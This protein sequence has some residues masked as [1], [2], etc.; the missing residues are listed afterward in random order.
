VLLLLLGAGARA[1]SPGSLNTSF[2]PGTGAN[3][4]VLGIVRQSD[5]KLVIGGQFTT[6]NGVARGRVARLNYDGSLDTSFD[7]GSGPDST[8]NAVAVGADG[9]VVAGGD[10]FGVNGVSR[11]RLAR[12]YVDGSLD[13]TFAPVVNG[14]IQA[15][16]VDPAGR[17]YL[18]GSFTLVN[19]VSRS[20]VARLNID[21]TLDLTF[22]PGTGP[23]SSV[24]GLELL[25][26]G[27]VLLAGYF[28]S[29]NGVTRHR[30]ARLNTDGTVDTTFVPG[31]LDNG[32]ANF[33]STGSDGK[34]LVGGGLYVGLNSRLLRLNPNGSVDTTFNVGNN[35]INSDVTT[36]VSHANGTVIIAGYFTAVNGVSRNSVARLL[37]NGTLDTAFNPGV[38]ANNRITEIVLEPDGSFVAGG[39]FT[40]YQGVSRNRITRIHSLF[41]NQAPV[42]TVTNSTILE[43][44]VLASVTVTGIAAGPV[45]DGLTVVPQAVTNLTATSSNPALVPDPLVTYTPGATTATLAFTP[46]ANATGTVTITVVAQ[47]NSG[48]A[49]LGNDRSTNT[50][51]L[52]VAP[53]NDAPSFTLATSALSSVGAVG[54][55]SV[56]AFAAN[57]LPGPANEA[58]QTVSFSVANNNNLLFSTQPAI[59]ANGTLTF[60]PAVM[61]NGVATVTVIAQ[62]NGGTANGGVDTSAAQTFTLTVV[63]GNVPPS[64]SYA[65]NNVVVLEDAAAQTVGAFA[66]FSAGPVNE[67]TQTVS[68]VSVTAANPALFSS[69]PALAANGTLTF[70]PAANANGATLVTVVVADDGGTAS[71]GAD[72]ATNTFTITVTPVNDAPGFALPAGPAVGGSGTLWS[73][74]YNEYG[75]IGNGTTANQLQP[76]AVLTTGVLADKTVTSVSVGNAHGLALCSDGTVAAWGR[77]LYGNLGTGNNN[78]SSVPVQVIQTGVLAGKTVTQVAAGSS[79]SLALC[80]DGT[81]VAWGQGNNGTLGNGGTAHVNQP[82]LV[83]QT[84]VLAGKTVTRIAGG[85]NQSFALCSDGTLVAWGYNNLGQLGTGSTSADVL[86]PALVDQSGVL[87]GKTVTK[88]AAG[89][90]HSLALCAD[91][92]LVAWGFNGSG[93]LGIGNLTS[94]ASPVLVDRSGVLAGKTVVEITVGQSHSAVLCA[95]GTIASWGRGYDSQLGNGTSTGDATLPVLVDRSGVLAGKTVTELQGGAVNTYALCSDGSVVVWGEGWFGGLGNGSTTPS[96]VPVLVSTSGLPA[97]QK[98]VKLFSGMSVGYTPMAMVGAGGGGGGGGAHTLTVAEDSGAYTGSGFVTSILTGPADESGQVV[99]F[100]VTS[101]NNALFASQPAIAADGTLTFTPAPNATGTATVTVRAQDDGGTANGGVDTSAA[102]TFTIVVNSVNDAPVITFA[103]SL[104]VVAEDSGAT[105]IVGFATVTTGPANESSQTITNFTVTSDN[106]TLFS[107]APALTGGALSFTPAA[108]ANGSALVTVVA[109]DDGGTDNGG[110]NQTTRTFTITVSDFNDPPVITFASNVVVLQDSGAASLATF[111][112]ITTGPANE[113][114]QSIT[115]LSVSNDNTA[116]FSAQ[117]ALSGGTL[118]FTPA[119]NAVGLAT[120]TVIAQDDGGTANGGVD[121][122]TNTFTISVIGVNH[123]PTFALRPVNTQSSLLNNGS[124]ETGSFTG[125][126]ATDTANSTPALAVRAN[127][128]NLGFFNVV[129]SDGTYSATHGFSGAT[130]GSISIAQDVTL[131]PGGG[132]TLSFA[133]RAAWQTFGAAADRVFRFVVQP[134]GGGADLLSQTILTATPNSFVFQTASTPVTVDLSAFAG[135]SVRLVLVTDIAAGDV[136]NGSFQLDNVRLSATTPN[137]TVFENSGASSTLNFATNI[138][139]GPAT[140]S[141]QTVAFLVANNNNDLFSSQPAVAADGTLT[142]TPALNANGLATVTVRAQDNGGTDNGGTD[143]SVPHT[144]SITVLPVNS[145]PGVTVNTAE[146]VVNE[147]RGAYSGAIATITTGP[148]DESGQSITNMVISNNNNALFSVQPAVSA[149]G[150]LTFTPTANAN[151]SAVVTLSVQDD[152]GTANGGVNLTTRTFTIT[153]TPVNDAPSFALP[154]GPLLPA[155][156]N[157]ILQSGYPQSDTPT[158]GYSPDGSR[159][160][161]GQWGGHSYLSTDHGL[162]WVARNTDT[163]R[164]YQ[165]GFA[166]SADGSRIYAAPRYAPML[167]SADGGTT[168]TTLPLTPG[169]NGFWTGVACS[170]SGQVVIG[171]N[172]D[173]GYLYTSTDYGAT[174]TAHLTDAVRGWGG[175][176]ASSDGSVLA[177]ASYARASGSIPDRIYISTDSGA[178]WT[179]RGPT[180]F[181]TGVACSA[182]GTKLVGTTD[183]GQIHTSTDGGLI[184][185][186]AKV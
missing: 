5:G 161:A 138:L 66:T 169:N 157:W 75:S 175:V 12:F 14:T 28:S 20:R 8:V 137:F 33:T 73:W 24:L 90:N 77:N 124:F 61:A 68:L 55:Q 123:A 155:G 151:G 94:S 181:W 89:A 62:D 142:F 35:V 165:G 183:G 145:A 174:W 63:S 27:K 57:I 141:A 150:V 82:V 52:T 64:A 25:A 139:A 154:L 42:F 15:V 7:P 38:G 45:G 167:T 144:F 148:A 172:G 32:Y 93:Q 70:T 18:A 149:G 164:A 110:A 97:G 107:V 3:S 106:P 65:T 10:F 99:S 29:V 88:L 168:W 163:T 2:N 36:A 21:G 171:G 103:A 34:I 112:S 19:G 178:T 91:G 184:G 114:S 119:L 87:A 131:P 44:S 177:A 58:G 162:T 84:G 40:T 173:F 22:A 111:A 121:K 16:A 80:S 17:V 179:A 166:F 92:T 39:D 156:Q 72:R 11:T 105:N 140:E 95:D 81:L 13:L 67:N 6:F 152:G 69:Q 113:S 56:P 30:V 120:V 48:T 136:G 186:R 71:G 116:L 129:S 85:G 43:D 86:V 128:A 153:V 134:G 158:I 127:A 26:D 101:D 76:V 60:T 23:N 53:V 37:A 130:A 79:H 125:W 160:M 50:F 109:Q 41:I 170:S 118:T 54:E 108:G 83:D 182:D 104:V 126:T 96:P 74:G 135:Q 9:K 117:P 4:R 102:Q 115:N 47:D 185:P 176:A 122:A 59:G 143:T 51:T 132:A 159:L 1:Q 133:Y 100:V 46:L 147:D 31:T 98:F 146:L 180:A 49:N 78:G